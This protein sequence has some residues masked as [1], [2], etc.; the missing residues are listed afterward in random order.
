MCNHNLE[1]ALLAAKL[2]SVIGLKNSEIEADT[3]Q[4]QA[5]S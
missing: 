1:N 2:A 5:M 4:F 3:R